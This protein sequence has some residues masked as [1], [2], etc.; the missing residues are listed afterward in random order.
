MCK[1]LLLAKEVSALLLHPSNPGAGSKMRL[2]I[3]RGCREGGVCGDAGGGSLPPV[4]SVGNIPALTMVTGRCVE[5]RA[6]ADQVWSR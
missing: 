1:W 6:I 2:P 4:V 3:Q 5:I